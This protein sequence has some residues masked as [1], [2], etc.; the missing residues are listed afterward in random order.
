MLDYQD[1]KNCIAEL[2]SFYGGNILNGGILEGAWY[3]SL[4]H[5]PLPKL[6]RAIALCFKKH[7]RAYNF[8][9]AVDQILEFATYPER[10]PGECVKQD[11]KAL[12][13][14]SHEQG[15]TPEQKTEAV[16]RGKLM[17]QIIINTTGFMTPEQ[18]DTLIEQLKQ[19]QTHELEAIASTARESQTYRKRGFNNLGSSLREYASN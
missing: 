18:K 9:P 8:F 2:Q 3:A 1:F 5:L 6:Q 11:F 17:A 19:K 7:P 16:L 4:K 15:I 13:L 12:C 14:P 10:P